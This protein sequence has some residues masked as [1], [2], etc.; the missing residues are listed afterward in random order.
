MNT[1]KIT[2]LNKLKEIGQGQILTLPG[3]DENPFVCK[4][5]RV[6][7]LGLA[8]KGTIP[9]SLLNSAQKIFTQ[10]V[11]SKTSLKEI[12]EVMKAIAKESLLEPTL[13]EIE[14]VG[15]DLTDEQLTVLLNYSQQGLKALESFRNEQPDI[16]NN[17]H[18]SNI[19][20]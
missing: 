9:N 16:K 15:L 11:D 2:N 19:Q 4:V 7:L 8:S 6:S 10:R 3:W 1:T 12:C 17:N 18:E 14:S 20:D 13:E 5:K